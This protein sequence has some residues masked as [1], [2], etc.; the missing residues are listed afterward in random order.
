MNDLLKILDSDSFEDRLAAIQALGEMGDENV[1]QLLRKRLAR[2]N[3]E[4]AV[5]VMAVGKLKK[6]LKVK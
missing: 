2:V 6:K 3:K 1:L 4:L 5:L